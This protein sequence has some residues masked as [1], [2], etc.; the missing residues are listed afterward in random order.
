MP[1]EVSLDT[2]DCRDPRI[3]LQLRRLKPRL[4]MH[5]TLLLRNMQSPLISAQGTFSLSTTLV[6]STRAARS[7]TRLANSTY[8]IGVHYVGEQ[9]AEIFIRRHLVRLWLRDEELAWKTPSSLQ[10]RWNRVYKGVT[11]AN[12]VFPLEPA[13]RSASKGHSKE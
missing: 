7:A 4:W 10:G 8:E 5:S 11:P 13:I 1:A 6:S 12:Q 2:G 9:A 3:S